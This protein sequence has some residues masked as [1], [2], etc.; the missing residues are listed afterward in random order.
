L[1]GVRADTAESRY[2]YGTQFCTPA[3]NANMENTF[4]TIGGYKDGHNRWGWVSFR[5]ENRAQQDDLLYDLIKDKAPAPSSSGKITDLLPEGLTY[6]A[7]DPDASSVTPTIVGRDR[8]VWDYSDFPAG[9]TTVTVIAE[10]KDYGTFVNTGNVAISG[11]SEETTNPTYHRA[12]PMIVSKTATTSDG[13]TAPGTSENPI[14]V[15]V[16]DQID[17]TVVAQNPTSLVMKN[18]VISDLLPAGTAYVSSDPEGTV[19]TEGGRQKIVWN[20]KEFNP[21]SRSFKVKVAVSVPGLH[22]NS[23]DVRADGHP[24]ITTNETCHEAAET[25]SQT[26]KIHL[27]QIVL[28]R[29]NSTIELPG[30]AY[31]ELTNNGISN[32]VTAESGVHGGSATDFTD[33]IVLPSSADKIY[34][35]V[36]LLPQYYEYAGYVATDAAAVH[37]PNERK[38]G[39]ISLDYAARNEYWVTVYIKPKALTP[40]DHTWDVHTN[41]FGGIFNR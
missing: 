11:H 40:A 18:A 29:N 23:A 16:G 38:M 15:K 28:E 41:Y 37:D 14:A 32:G 27:R 7:S 9:E 24:S 22:R 3:H 17:Y 12:R 10:V 35:V 26:R 31:M 13:I 6:V 36:D 34:Q 5:E 2:L 1:I 33:Y 21:G 4:V 30:M 39:A 20:V 25:A 8:V 19:T